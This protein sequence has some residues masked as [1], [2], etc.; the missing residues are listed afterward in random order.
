[1]PA[2]KSGL[3]PLRMTPLTGSFDS[4]SMPELVSPNSWRMLQ[5][6]R[7]TAR[8]RICRMPGWEKFLAGFATNRAYNN[9]DLHD[10]LLSL[11]TYYDVLS[12]VDGSAVVAYPPD[13]ATFGSFCGTT[14]RTRTQGRQPITFGAEITS[15]LGTR[16][17]VV[18]TQSRLYALN[19]G[20]GNWKIIADGLGG[21]TSNPEVRFQHAALGDYVFF[22]NNF[23]EL[24]YW[25]IDQPMSGCEMQSVQ[26][27]PE[28]QEIGVTKVRC[29][30]SFK[31]TLFLAN[32]EQDGERRTNRIIW[33]RYQSPLEV[34]EDPGVST[35]GT[36]DLDFGEE[37]VAVK[38]LGDFLYFYTDRAIWVAVVTDGDSAFAF[39]RKYRA[40]TK[41]D[42]TLVYPFTLTGA[43]DSHFYGST[44]GIYE[45]NPYI[46]APVRQEW[47]HQSSNILYDNLNRS[48]CAAHTAGYS[49]TLNEMWF[50]FAQGTN[51]L[52]SVTL[53]CNP[54][55]GQ[56]S[57]IDHGF[58]CLFSFT[59][60]TRESV[61]DFLLRN[62]I[63]DVACL[64]NAELLALGFSQLKE[65]P[66]VTNT[67]PPCASLVRHV[68]T[69]VSLVVVSPDTVTEDY[70][71]PE[72]SADSICAALGDMNVADGCHNCDVAALFIGAS[73]TD[74]CL[75]Q[76]GTIYA[77]ERYDTATSTYVL[78]GYDT[79]MLK[80]P[81]MFGTDMQK[82]IEGVILEF[83]AEPQT[84][85]SNMNLRVGACVRC[86]DPLKACAIQWYDEV[87]RPIQCVDDD[88]NMEWAT[89]AADRALYL[90]F[91]I[92]GKG[93][94]SCYSSLQVNVGK[95]GC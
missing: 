15:S 30:A 70:T 68:Y 46:M 18:G 42:G 37:I 20:T 76:I 26:T 34:V 40:N 54:V 90:E 77:R 12:D 58:T 50:S 52:P 32:V 44:E 53:S 82:Q 29:L 19:F 49:P 21:T 84:I 67:T 47:I 3:Q 27:V 25:Q 86:D 63:A 55:Y 57:K 80:G 78:D 62:C 8:G 73:A 66:G 33:S 14:K 16:H 60:D 94:A 31:G 2:K 56:C 13:N 7:T 17:C 64:N 74:W 72:A 89:Y 93:G 35:A 75:K 59:P 91:K 61:R 11:Q 81:M 9:E 4:R 65:G 87:P 41:G 45:W 43:K 1:M 39:V 36:Q 28:L 71:Q 6:T 10:Q 69:G 48:A 88:R 24:F 5:N 79:I 85:P 38:E 51:K 95:A 92:T 83:E 22:T 23:D